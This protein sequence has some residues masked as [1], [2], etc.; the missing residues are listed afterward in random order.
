MGSGLASAGLILT[1]DL[2]SPWCKTC[3]FFCNRITVSCTS[4]HYH[5]WTLNKAVENLTVMRL[6]SCV[7]MRCVL[8]DRDDGCVSASLFT[9]NGHTGQE[10]PGNRCLHGLWD[11]RLLLLNIGIGCPGGWNR[12]AE[13]THGED[14][15][16][17]VTE[18]QAFS[19]SM[20]T[21]CL[22]V[23]LCVCPSVCLSVEILSRRSQFHNNF[24][25]TSAIHTLLHIIYG[26]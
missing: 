2:E 8:D 19:W 1:G 24:V 5:T 12:A 14:Y 3:S 15:T 16:F 9:V 18:G 20:C 23:C 11:V 7:N 4:Y 13:N 17:I 10:V 6:A 22:S 26:G 25:S 21:F